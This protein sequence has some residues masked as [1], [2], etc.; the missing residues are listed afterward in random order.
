MSTT[1][2]VAILALLALAGLPVLADLDQGMSYFKSGKFVEAVAEFQTLVD[3]S[4]SYD[5]GYFMMGLSFLKMNK[6]AEAEKNLLQA[7]E[8][9]GDRFEY[10]HALANAY[11]VAKQYPKTVA[12]LKTAEGLAAD[13][14]TQG[15]LYNLRGLAYAALEKW[16][17][18]VE[19]LERARAIEPSPAILDRLGNAYYELG[20]YD[21]AVPVLRDVLKATPGQAA[22]Q[23]RLAQAL[24][25][26]GAETQDDAK[27]KAYYDE[28]FKAAQE[29]KRLR[30]NT[31]LAHNLA[32]RA[33]LG[34]ADYHTAEQAFRQVLALE[35]D[36]C[37]AM[38]NLGKTYIAQSRWKEAEEILGDAVKCA[39][40]MAVAYEGLGFSQQKQMRL[41][42]AM[43]SY[44]KAY[45]IKP[46]PGIMASIETCKQNIE[47][48]EHNKEADQL[49]A[50]QAALVQA[51][52]ER[53]RLE[54]EKIEAWKKKQEE[55]Q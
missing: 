22:A 29:Y 35:S 10:H 18:A 33:A 49:A 44:E 41:E 52:E 37:Y 8:L 26:L 5:Y 6:P 48:R 17:D 42:Q 31:S 15:A 46:S 27:K 28:A 24:L 32:G 25:E 1:R 9:N 30:P 39:P 3:Q 11:F 21:K 2:S 36:H 12:T 55:D 34:A 43:K 23:S 14:K 13:K 4:P 40:R 45:E 38:A 50:E 51:E 16:P 53:I 47:I 20:H 19:D 54:K 7:I